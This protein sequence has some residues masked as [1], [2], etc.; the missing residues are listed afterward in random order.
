MSV[1]A[2]RPERVEVWAG[3]PA[4]DVT[5]RWYVEWIEA[6]NSSGNIAAEYGSLADAMDDAREWGLPVF[7][8]LKLAS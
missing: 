4:G 2:F 3:I 1:I 5:P 7:M 6:G 8:P